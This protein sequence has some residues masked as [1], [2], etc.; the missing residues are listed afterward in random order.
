MTIDQS[1]HLSK[2][3]AS[4]FFY[5]G[6]WVGDVLEAC[7]TTRLKSPESSSLREGTGDP[8]VTR[9]QLPT[10]QKTHANGGMWNGKHCCDLYGRAH[11]TCAFDMPGYG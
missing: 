3:L 1:W 9:M 11:L 7:N 10:A 8:V 4:T 2:Y 6:I 5:E